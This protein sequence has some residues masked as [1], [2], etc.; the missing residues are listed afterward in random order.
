MVWLL[1]PGIDATTGLLLVIAAFFT[2]ALTAAFGIGGGVA[3]L[4]IL[5]GSAPPALIIAVHGLVQL[6]SNVG[7]AIVQRQ[8][9]AWPLTRRF[10]IGSVIGVGLG[11]SLFVALPERALLIALGLFILVMVFMPKPNLPGLARAGVFVGGIVSSVLTM[12][13][14]ATGPFIQATLFPLGLT[15]QQLI[16]THAACMSLQHGLKVLAFGLL[17]LAI[18]AWLPLIALM[19]ASGFAGTLLGT[20][21][22]AALPETLFRRLLQG[23]LTL[24]ALDLLRRGLF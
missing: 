10:V 11:A 22:L 12:F 23:L 8:H 20:R 16:A 1:P 4:G 2:S 5:A 21:L 18:G 15:R 13:V 24:I 6:G 19:I 17:G 7:R 3:M 14:G 9:V